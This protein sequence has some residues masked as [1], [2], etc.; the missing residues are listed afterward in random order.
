MAPTT[1]PTTVWLWPRLIPGKCVHV[2][3]CNT[4]NS[5]QFRIVE[6]ASEK[7]MWRNQ[8]LPQS[9]KLYLGVK[10]ST[11]EGFIRLLCSSEVQ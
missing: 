3:Y 5:I 11:N 9:C 7:A 2:Q 10:K 4:L 8:A 1:V 6:K